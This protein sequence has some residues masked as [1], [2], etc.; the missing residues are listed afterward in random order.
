MLLFCHKLKGG[1]D[2]CTFT[3]NLNFENDG[4]GH[5]FYGG[6]GDGGDIDGGGGDGRGCG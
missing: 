1:K 4:S 5:F 6:D 2:T 3:D